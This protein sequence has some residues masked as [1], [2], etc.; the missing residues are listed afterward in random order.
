M[1]RYQV[2]VIL[3]HCLQDFPAFTLS[4]KYLSLT[5]LP[6]WVGKSH[7]PAKKIP[8]TERRAVTAQLGTCRGCSWVENPQIWPEKT[9]PCR[10]TSQRGLPVSPMDWVT[11]FSLLLPA[12]A[13]AVYKQWIPNTN[14]ETASNWEKGRVPCASDV[15][16]F[17]KNK[18]SAIFML[19]YFY[20]YFN[21]LQNAI[22]HSEK[23]FTCWGKACFYFSFSYRLSQ[24]SSGLPM[25]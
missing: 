21:F 6:T 5:P 13:A 17:E 7:H 12:A 23:P 8:C 15:V 20:F 16:R 10:C 3:A 22:G 9:N 2:Y 18:V 24:S 19:F 4:A 11:L 14:F 25:H 1:L